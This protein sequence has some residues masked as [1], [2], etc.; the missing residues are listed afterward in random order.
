MVSLPLLDLI[1]GHQDDE[2]SDKVRQEKLTIEQAYQ[3]M[4]F[5]LEHEY[6][7]T[8]SDEIGGLLGSLSLSIW[9]DGKPADPAAWQ[10]WLD[11]VERAT[12]TS[13]TKG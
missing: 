12:N 6:E 10:D 8:K 2:G 1:G 5:F 11:A 9:S 3:A 13:S 4:V 7:L